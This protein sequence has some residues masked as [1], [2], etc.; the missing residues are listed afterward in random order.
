MPTV[1]YPGSFD[2]VSNGHEDI[3]ARISA[4]FTKVYVLV[5]VNPIKPQSTFSIEERLE[6]L[7]DVCKKYPNVEVVSTHG[8]VVD[9]A[10]QVG[11]SLI[12][13]GVRNS[14]DFLMEMSQYH[15]N[16]HLKP[17]IDTAVFLA[18][19]EHIFIASSAIRELAAL[20]GDIS[21]YVPCEIVDRI[22]QKYADK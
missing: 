7:R 6:M 19:N 10:A 18:A 11:A 14:A 12:I 13:K 4:Q 5:A 22:K 16:R 9:F 2:P 20:G 21:Q 3:I 17:S 15:Y 1:V 8:F